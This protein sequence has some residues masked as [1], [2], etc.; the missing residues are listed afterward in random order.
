MSLL[1]DVFHLVSVAEIVSEITANVELKFITK[2]LI[3][4]S[5][6]VYAI[7]FNNANNGKLSINIF[8]AIF[9]AWLGDSFLLYDSVEIFFILG[10]LS[11]LV[12]QFFYISILRNFGVKVLSFHRLFLG[13]YCGI[14]NYLIFDHVGDL[15]IPVFVFSLVV[16][17]TGISGLEM[18]ASIQEK[19]NVLESSSPV[20]DSRIVE[21]RQASSWILYGVVFF[22]ICDTTIAFTKFGVLTH[23]LEYQAFIMFCYIV[24]QGF[25]VLGSLK[26]YNLN[27]FLQQSLKIE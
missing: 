23:S 27:D 13:I 25:L 12:M 14:L 4:L 17:A 3:M 7:Y 5:L 16:C 22:V 10:L 21:S 20:P 19:L 2:P 15:R 8:L 1:I 18:N 26:L 11:H 6:F 9:F 24:A